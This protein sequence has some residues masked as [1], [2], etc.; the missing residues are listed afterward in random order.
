MITTVSPSY[1][2]EILTPQFGCGL[3]G[4]LQKRRESIRGILNGADYDVW[5]PEADRYL[6]SCYSAGRMTGKMWCKRKLIREFYLSDML[7]DRPILGFIG[8]LRAQK[9]IDLLI[10]IIPRLMKMGVAWLFWARATCGP[11]P[12]FWT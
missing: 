7:E 2:E 8:R 5:A 6:P 9:G 1:A 12:N 11:R 4:I 10:D 3:E